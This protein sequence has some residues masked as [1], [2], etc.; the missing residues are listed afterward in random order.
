[1]ESSEAAVG[2]PGKVVLESEESNDEDDATSA[3]KNTM[4]D[5]EVRLTLLNCHYSC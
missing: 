5:L 3:A 1:M 4:S 2:A